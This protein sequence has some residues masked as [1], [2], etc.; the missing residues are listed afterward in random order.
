MQLAAAGASMSAG[1]ARGSLMKTT[2]LGADGPEVSRLGVGCSR[3]STPPRDDAESIA[4]LHALLDAGVNFLDT[5]DFYG[6]GHNESL[7]GRAIKDRREQ[8]KCPR[9]WPL[10]PHQASLHVC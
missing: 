6:M 4:T 8:A 10:A 3:M 7:I 5:A 1:L 2:R 9:L